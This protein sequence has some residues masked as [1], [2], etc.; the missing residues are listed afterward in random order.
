VRNRQIWGGHGEFLAWTA[1]NGY[2]WVQGSSPAGV[3]VNFC[4]PS[5]QKKSYR[6]P[7]SGLLPEAL[8]RAGSAPWWPLHSKDLTLGARDSWPH[9]SS[10]KAWH[11][12][13]KD[14]L[15][16]CPSL[17]AAC[18]RWESW[19]WGNPSER[20]G[21]VP[22][23]LQHSGKRSAL[24]PGSTEEALVLK[25]QASQGP[26]LRRADP[27]SWKLQHW[28]SQSGQCGR[29]CLGND[30]GA[31]EQAHWPIQLPSRAR[32]RALTWPTP[33]STPSMICWSRRKD[34]SCR[35]KAAG[36]L[37]QRTLPGYLRGVPVRF[38]YK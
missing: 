36:S 27:A 20:A 35:S 22:H 25:E 16:A 34:W 7:W 30:A 19:H 21:T 14:L 13:G 38:Q 10:A 12:W 23:W 31:E 4:G 11:E 6:C 8:C 32:S 28:V 9:P 29:A 33:T 15:P 18:G 2:V 24:H 37:W 3:C 17:L 5:Y 1:A 26:K